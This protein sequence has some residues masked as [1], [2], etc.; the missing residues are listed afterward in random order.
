LRAAPISCHQRAVLPLQR[1][2][3]PALHVEEEPLELCV[4]GHRLHDQVVGN[5]VVEGLDVKI[6][7]PVR[8]P[9]PLST[10][11]HRLYGRPPW[12]VPV[13]VVMEDRFHV[14]LQVHGGHG[15]SDPVRHGGHSEHSD[16]APR[17]LRYLYRSHRGR[18]VAARGHPVPELVEIPFQVPLELHNGLPVDTGCAFVGLDASVCLPDDLL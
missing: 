9:A 18:E 3:Q 10:A 14:R 6:D 4:L 15:L 1:G 17:L 12:P 11:F 7:D 2:F 5:G 13:G 16:P 8:P